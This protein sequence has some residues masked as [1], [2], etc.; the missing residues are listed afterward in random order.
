M[1]LICNSMINVI[2]HL[3]VCF[4]PYI[5]LREV[6]V[7]SFA[8][9]CRAVCSHIVEFWEFFIY[10]RDKFCVRNM[11]CKYFHPYGGLLFILLTVCFTKQF[12]ILIRF[13]LLHFSFMNCTLGIKYESFYQIKGHTD[14]LLFFFLE[15]KSM[16]IYEAIF[17]IRNNLELRFIFQSHL[18]NSSSTI[19]KNLQ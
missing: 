2:E 15:I 14:F 9:F 3:F 18:S 17:G 5:F 13:N 12:L 6:S 1:D 8:H 4:S 11:I 19:L 10:L 7:Q 16:I